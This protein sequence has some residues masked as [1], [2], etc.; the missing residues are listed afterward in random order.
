M[1]R[2]CATVIAVFAMVSS[3]A[4]GQPKAVTE[5]RFFGA[6]EDGPVVQHP[7]TLSDADL[8]ALGKDRLMRHVLQQDPPIPAVT[9]NGLEAGVVH[10][11]GSNEKDLI[12]VGSG[13]P[14]HGANVVPFWMIRELPGGPTV[15]F[16]TIT[17][18]LSIKPAKHNGLND[19]ECFAATAVSSWTTRY[20]FDG[21]TYVRAWTREDRH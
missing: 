1:K 21:T 8:I 7:I 6:G 3:T 11:M 9:R 4:P 12:V 17:L 14:Y 13:E 20:Q 10:L 5:Q 19:I 16:S 15:V 18:S 2:L